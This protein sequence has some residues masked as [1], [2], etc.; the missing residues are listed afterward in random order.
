MLANHETCF[1]L[2]GGRDEN[3]LEHFSFKRF[4][5]ILYCIPKI[6]FEVQFQILPDSVLLK[7]RSSASFK[8]YS[9][10][11]FFLF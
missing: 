6:A 4:Q 5:D 1:I 3:V 2:E 8:L 10:K 11:K 7:A 9:G